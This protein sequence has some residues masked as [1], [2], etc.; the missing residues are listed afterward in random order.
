MRIE[1]TEWLEVCSWLRPVRDA[2]SKVTYR[3]WWLRLGTDSDEAIWIQWAFNATDVES[4]EA[5]EHFCRKW[6]IS[7]HMTDAEI[8]QTAFAAALAAEEH[9]CRE[10]FKYLGAPIFNPH[11]SLDA[12]LARAGST[13]VRS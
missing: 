11:L 4:G 8:V 7:S 9:E 10:N 6:R 3:D 13:E 1:V 12:L 2:L 5:R